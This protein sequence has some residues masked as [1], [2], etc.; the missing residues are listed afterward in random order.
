MA[1]F[2]IDDRT[3]NDVT[4]DG[5]FGRGYVERDYKLYPQEYLAAPS[6]MKLI[7]KT[8][9]SDRIKEKA[10]RKSQTSDIRRFI[11]LNQGSVGY[12][13]A[14]STAHAVM[15]LRDLQNQPFVELSAYAVAAI[16]KRGRDEGGWCGLSAKFLREVGIPTTKFWPQGNRSLSL[17]TAEMRANAALHKVT[18]EFADLTQAVYD[19]NLT[20]NQLATCLLMNVP[21]AVDFNWWGHSVCAMDLVEPEPGDFGIRILNSWPPDWGD[22]KGQAVLRGSK[23]IPN[24]AIALLTTNATVN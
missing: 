20:F 12:C 22:G 14:H 10:A 21:C 16:I 6:T 3:N 17:D 15:L 24:G 1:D 19:Q 23:C 11:N 8:E 5:R 13:W 2:I 18:N 4:H 7:P 9:W